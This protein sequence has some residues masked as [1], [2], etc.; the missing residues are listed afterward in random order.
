MT[1][2]HLLKIVGVGLMLLLA[3]QS[4]VSLQKRLTPLSLFA[5]P[6]AL[7]SDLDDARVHFQPGGED[8]ARDVAALMGEATARVV[9]AQGKPFAKEPIV[10]VYTSYGDYGRSNGY[11]DV[12]ILATARSGRVLLSPALC[13]EDKP[14]LKKVLTHEL[15]HTHLFGWRGVIAERP[16]SWFTEGLAVMI[17]DGGGAESVDEKEALAALK[18]GY[19]IKVAETG[20]WRDFNSIPFEKEPKPKGEGADFFRYRQNLA[21]REAGLFVAWLKREQP[22][23]FAK[24]LTKLQDGAFFGEAFKE[25]YGASLGQQWLKFRDGAKG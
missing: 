21:F 18:D 17:S 5:D 2:W 11:D 19:A 12:G 6:A 10:V 15:S 14:K 13:H 9:A 24:L 3:Y 7:P 16:P 23:A 1:V 25:A 20:V 22:E 4:V 8:C